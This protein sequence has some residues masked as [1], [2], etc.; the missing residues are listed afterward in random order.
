M[1]YCV[2]NIDPHG[3][4]QYEFYFFVLYSGWLCFFGKLYEYGIF[5]G[6]QPLSQSAVCEMFAPSQLVWSPK[7]YYINELL[8]SCDINSCD[9]CCF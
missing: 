9:P 2:S 7:G 8:H 5:Y 3:S 1:N 4:D 6:N